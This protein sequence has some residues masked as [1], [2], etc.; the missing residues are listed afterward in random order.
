MR[1][2]ETIII[3]SLLVLALLVF[4]INHFLSKDKTMV[5]VRNAKDELLL[6]IN[7]NED[8]YYTLTGDYGTFN[9][10]VKDGQ[11]RAIDVECPNQI[12]VHTGWISKSYPFPIICIPNNIVVTIDE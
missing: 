4:G 1:K 7:I 3:I 11:I 10:E 12:C 8:N 5:S 2:K 6:H 9:L